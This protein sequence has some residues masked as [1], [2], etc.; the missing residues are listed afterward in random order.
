MERQYTA[1]GI[2]RALLIAQLMIVLFGV[3]AAFAGKSC[4]IVYAND[5]G[6]AVT[7]EI[8]THEY[9]HCNGWQHAPGYDKAR[10]YGKAYLPPKRFLHAF[11]G[12]VEE[13]SVSTSEARDR[14]EGELGCQRFY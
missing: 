14:C 12:H 10:G 9:A 1:W 7:R 8:R 6:R 11:N 5:M 2:M 4:S 13:S 3:V